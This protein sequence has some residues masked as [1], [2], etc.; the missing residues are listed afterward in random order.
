MAAPI[1]AALRAQAAA[2]RLQAEALD[3]LASV[4][5]ASEPDALLGVEECSALGV[6]RDALRG[7]A[8][9]GELDVS[10]GPRGKLLVRRSA[11]EAWLQS[12]KYTP[13]ARSEQESEPDLA[14]WEK[15]VRRAS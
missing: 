14:A 11:I 7:A 3:T 10:T 12:R 2:L 5:E 8:R 1:S 4:A 15:S 13:S 9:R 6:G